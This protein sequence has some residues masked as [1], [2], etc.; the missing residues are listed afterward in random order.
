VKR[1]SRASVENR[2]KTMM[3]MMMI[4]SLL[5]GSIKTF[6]D[7]RYIEDKNIS[8]GRYCNVLSLGCSIIMLD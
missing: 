6:L 5:T 2:R 7:I 3:M 1:L 8:D 4:Y